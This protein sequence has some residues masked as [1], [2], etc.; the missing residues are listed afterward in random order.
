MYPLVLTK[1]QKRRLNLWLKS[2]G[3][4]YWCGK[5]TILDITGYYYSSDDLATIDHLNNRVNGIRQ[6]KVVNEAKTV[7]ACQKC[8]STRHAR[9]DL[10]NQDT[11]IYR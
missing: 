11:L 1:K 10:Y 4:C 2:N 6:N 8:N 7:L 5:K 3:R 9:V